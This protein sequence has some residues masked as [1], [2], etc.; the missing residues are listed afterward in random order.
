MLITSQ[1]ILI[2]SAAGGVGIAAIQLAQYIE[3]E[4][5]ILSSSSGFNSP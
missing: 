2:H 4:V 3:A 5:S 1:S